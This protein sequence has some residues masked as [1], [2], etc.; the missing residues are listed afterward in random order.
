M[1]F[2]IITHLDDLVSKIQDKPEIN[3]TKQ[4]NGTT[5]VCYSIATA[6]T[7]D[8]PWARECRGIT[9]GPDGNVISRSLHKF[10]NLNENDF[11]RQ[12]NLEWEKVGRVMDKLDGSMISTMVLNGGV[13]A[14]SKKSF[15]SD[16]AVKAQRFFDTNSN[17]TAFAQWIGEMGFTPTFEYTAP[18]N[19]IVLPYDSEQMTLLH[20]RNN[21]TGEY[22]CMDKLEGFANY[23]QIPIVTNVLVGEPLHFLS[24][25]KD[26]ED[27][28]GA[29]FQFADGDMV[30]VKTDWYVKLHRTIV[31]I[32]ERDIAEMILDETLDDVK[33]PLMKIGVDLSKIE[34]IEKRVITTIGEI[35][36]SV[37]EAVSQTC[38]MT[39]KEVA[40]KYQGHQ[41]FG[42]IM[43]VFRGKDPDYVG[44]FRAHVLKEQYSLEQ[45]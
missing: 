17:F 30:K 25:L 35:R 1:A 45:I 23:Y 6:S 13:L 10:F 34:A 36:Q 5:I 40:L 9:F 29:I 16:V 33:E 18:D 31:F 15:S 22:W 11:A 7:F 44:Y 39:P 12:E 21:V 20:V 32:R 24:T 19:R 14:K 4:A 42:L 43:S 26:K 41:F 37:E 38:G 28:E 3:V 27:I 8:N 2:P